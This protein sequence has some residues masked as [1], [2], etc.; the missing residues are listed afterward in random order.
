MYKVGS[1]CEWLIDIFY[2]D[3]PEYFITGVTI[4]DVI[5]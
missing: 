5:N 2:N 1:S 3:M 4:D